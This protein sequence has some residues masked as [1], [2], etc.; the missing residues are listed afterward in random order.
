[1]VCASV[2]PAL[3][4]RRVWPLKDNLCDVCTLKVC[5][6]EGEGGKLQDMI[7]PRYVHINNDFNQEFTSWS[8]MYLGY[9]TNFKALFH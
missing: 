4:L 1:M 5:S 9:V 8:C 6:R 7:Q 2:L 3:V